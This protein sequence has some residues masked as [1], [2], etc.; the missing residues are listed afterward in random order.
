MEDLTRARASLTLGDQGTFG[1]AGRGCRSPFPGSWGGKTA[2]EP[3]KSRNESVTKSKAL[4]LRENGI[5][6][7][8]D[9]VVGRFIRAPR[10]G[11]QKNANFG[12]V[13]FYV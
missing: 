6:I 5:A 12:D 2:P 10:A 8:A 7:T 3:R 9:N 13:G 11:V 1:R 4:T